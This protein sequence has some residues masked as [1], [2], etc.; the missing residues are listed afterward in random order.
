MIRVSIAVQ[1]VLRLA[2]AAFYA[3]IIWSYLPESLRAVSLAYERVGTVLMMWLP[4]HLIGGATIA[5]SAWRLPRAKDPAG[6][7][8]WTGLIVLSLLV[9]APLTGTFSLVKKSY[10]G[11]TKMRLLELREALKAR[12][13]MRDPG[14][15][16]IPYYHKATALVRYGSAADDA[17]G[18]MY[19]NAAGDP[20]SGQVWVNCTHTDARGT[21]WSA[22]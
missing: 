13:P 16:A 17:G 7:A 1:V 3:A 5:W 9:A 11:R 10:A 8:V 6:A 22:Y 14:A 21:A 12:K 2:V 4:V 15:A 18:W 19:D 20:R